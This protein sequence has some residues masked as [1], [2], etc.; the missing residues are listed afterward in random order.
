[1][2]Y[3]WIG[4]CSFQNNY[5]TVWI[6]MHNILI[7]TFRNFE[8]LWVMLSVF[9]QNEANKWLTLTRWRYNRYMHRM[10]IS[11]RHEHSSLFRFR[12]LKRPPGIYIKAPVPNKE[13]QEIVCLTINMFT[14]CYLSFAVFWF[15]T[16]WQEVMSCIC[17][18]GIIMHAFSYLALSF[19]WL[20]SSFKNLYWQPFNTLHS[21]S[22]IFNLHNTILMCNCGKL[23]IITSDLL[24]FNFKQLNYFNLFM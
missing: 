22:C 20:N 13:P 8:I 12:N 15:F 21:L 24:I 5:T 3:W 4:N 6:C 19:V 14:S 16:I 18:M 1:M 17:K 9:N 2:T 11:W 23:F 10:G 7:I